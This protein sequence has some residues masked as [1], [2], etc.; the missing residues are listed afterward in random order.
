MIHSVRKNCFPAGIPQISKLTECTVIKLFK[1]RYCLFLLLFLASAILPWKHIHSSCHLI[2]IMASYDKPK[3]VGRES[4]ITYFVR[5]NNLICWPSFQT[6]LSH[7]INSVSE[8]QTKVQLH[9]IILNKI[10]ILWKSQWSQYLIMLRE[11]A[12]QIGRFLKLY[13]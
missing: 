7:F 5:K 3:S 8:N 2:S 1:L 11:I 13:F 6:H 12:F 9:W 4:K 10:C